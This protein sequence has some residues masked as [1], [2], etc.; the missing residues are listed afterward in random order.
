M[1][2][3]YELKQ[4]LSY[5]ILGQ[6][7][8]QSR[9][10]I[11]E[12]L[13]ERPYNI[14]QL[15]EKLDLNYRTV[16]HHIDMLLRHGLIGTSRTGGYG[17]VY[18]VSP[19]LET[20]LPLFK[21]IANKLETITTSPKFFQS[22]MEQTND[23]VLI[24]DEKLD[25]IFWNRS[26]EELFGHTG[27][28]VMG[29]RIPV[30]PDT[31]ALRRTLALLS[32]G[33]KVVGLEARAQTKTGKVLDLELT[34]DAIRDDENRLIGYSMIC[35]DITDRKLALEALLISQQR[36]ALA[37]Q[38]ARILSWEWDITSDEMRW[39]ERPGPFLGLGAGADLGTFK[40]FLRHVH[41][42]DRPLVAETAESIRKR[43]RDISIEHR[44]TLPDGQVRWIRHTGGVIRDDK[45]KAQ[46][47]VGIIQDITE[48]RDAERRYERVI[49]TSLDGFW[50]T[51]MKG[52]FLEANDA[53]C[54]MIGQSRQRLLRL[55]IKDFEAAEKPS[56]TMR[57]IQKL[58]REGSDRFETRHRRKDG[59]LVDLDVSAT[60]LESEGGRLVVFLR[61]IT[62][63]KKAEAALRLSEQRYAL[64][65]RAASIGSWDWDIV[66]GALT[67]SDTIEPMFGFS[68]GKFKGTYAAFLKCV[69][70]D[71][72]A[73][74]EGSVKASVDKKRPYD[75][76]HR[77]VWPDG[78]VHWM[79]ER[80]EVLRDARGRPVRML[81]VVQDITDRKLNEERIRHLASFPRL[82]PNPVMELDLEGNVTYTNPATAGVLDAAGLKSPSELRPPDFMQVLE[83]LR[84]RPGCTVYRDIHVGK[85]VFRMGA[86]RPPGLPHYRLYGIDITDRIKAEESLEQAR[87]ALAR[88][89]RMEALGR[90]A[91]AT[92]Q[93]LS[94]PL[95]AIKNAVYYLDMVA[96]QAGPEITEALDILH[97]EV[98][99]SEALLRNLG[100]I[101]QARPPETGRVDIG[102]L[103]DRTLSSMRIP[104]VIAV[105]RRPGNGLPAIMADAGQL[106]VVF[107][108]LVQNAIE[109]MPDGGKLEIGVAPGDSCIEVSIGDTGK[110]ISE[111]DLGRLFDTFYTTKP[112]GI[113][114]G[115][116]VARQLVEG[117]GGRIEVRSQPGK[118]STFTV[119]LPAGKEGGPRP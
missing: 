82:N 68:P 51:D 63:R 110:G 19:E 75:I 73:N 116:P 20:R 29:S 26:A 76:E 91:G 39:S 8:G 69:H 37:Q 46:K 74:V 22:V 89:D 23:A 33:K 16:R 10:Q 107:R 94:V 95:T 113:G 9:V 115:L 4:K 87:L 28:D 92:G 43:G 100:D 79:S 48:R 5:I 47:L 98:A 18:F 105:E 56:D 83:E 11:I 42:A 88:K 57:H 50:I 44:V 30:F 52:R 38:A 99:A 71:D 45:G 66:T 3:N 101:A 53:Y 36:Y 72:R 112:R 86:S 97:R 25:V 32:E 85:Q 109:A 40:A 117:H 102:E 7:G 2:S 21:E 54:R 1:L 80:G 49:E 13:V 59:S 93:E 12:S 15:A 58:R 81:G 106:G 34:I 61:D 60:Y 67:W 27:E 111:K 14:N 6:R 64:A 55:S 77:V 90:L 17:E 114:L 104:E 84:E 118:G 62:E 35:L 65:Q 31:E 119:V 78:S 24:I 41:P 96:G 70:P 103:L 108:N